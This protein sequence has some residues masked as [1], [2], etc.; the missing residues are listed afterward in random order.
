MEDP[1]N[2]ITVLEHLSRIGLAL[3]IDDYG[4]G[5]SS[6]SYLMRLPAKE[7]KIDRSFVSQV[8]ATRT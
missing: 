3:S 5:Y 4:T 6:L 2:A 7:L 8:S 1:A